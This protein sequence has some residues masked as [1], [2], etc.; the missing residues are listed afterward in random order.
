M[1]VKSSR[2]C[3]RC[4]FFKYIRL[5]G[6]SGF[7]GTLFLHGQPYKGVDFE[8]PGGIAPAIPRYEACSLRSGIVLQAFTEIVYRKRGGEDRLSGAN[9]RGWL[10]WD[11]SGQLKIVGRTFNAVTGK[12]GGNEFDQTFHRGS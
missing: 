4:L 3:I 12:R 1:T 11:R 2:T 5:R 10:C 7:E 9:R 6:E 8:E